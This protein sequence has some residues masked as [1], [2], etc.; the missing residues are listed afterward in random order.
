[1]EQ[2]GRQHW[3]PGFVPNRDIE[4]FMGRE[5]DPEEETMIKRE[6]KVILDRCLKFHGETDLS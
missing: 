1:M 6:L 2:R 3:A 5:V 4:A